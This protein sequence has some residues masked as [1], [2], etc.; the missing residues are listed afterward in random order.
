MVIVS[1]ILTSLGEMFSEPGVKAAGTGSEAGPGTG[2]GGA[3]A[4]I[5]AKVVKCSI[6]A[7]IVLFSVST[8]QSSSTHLSAASSYQAKIKSSSATPSGMSPGS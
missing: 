4:P 1:P 5:I 3:A 6:E 7:V 8:T 2:S